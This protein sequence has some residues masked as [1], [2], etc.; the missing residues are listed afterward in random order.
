MDF[1]R[2]NESMQEVRI[3]GQTF[4][5][6]VFINFVL[7]CVS[8]LKH[9]LFDALVMMNATLCTFHLSKVDTKDK[10]DESGKTLNYIYM[11]FMHSY[12]ENIIYMKPIKDLPHFFFGVSLLNCV[13]GCLELIFFDERKRRQKT[14]TRD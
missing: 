8:S 13:V 3:E 12:F 2:D 14:H 7:Q 4:F 9:L 10:S 6:D 1:S 5:F 11:R